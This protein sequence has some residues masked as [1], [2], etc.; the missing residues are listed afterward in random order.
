M[1]PD[2]LN[3]LFV[4]ISALDGVGPENCQTV[5]APAGRGD[6]TEPRIVR[7]I[8][9]LPHAVID[10][11]KQPGIA[12]SPEGAIV[13]LKVRVDRHQPSPPGKPNHPYKVFVHDDTGEL[14]LT[15]FHMKQP[16][17]E[18]SL[19]IGETVFV[20]GKME[21]FNGRPTMV[22][23]D[24]ITPESGLDALPLIEPVYAMTEGL[25]PKTI[26]K[27]VTQALAR[28]PE[29]PE[30]HDPAL[31]A[32]QSFKPF[33]AALD[34]V[35]HPADPMDIDPQSSSRRRL[36][37]DELLA[38]Q[39]S[40]ALVRSRM[41]KMP[42]KALT[43]NGN[44]RVKLLHSI[45]YSL[46]GSQKTALAEISADLSKPDRMLRLL[47]GDVGSGK[48]IVALLAM[49][50]AAEAGGQSALMA[51]TEVLARQHLCDNWAA[52]GTSGASH[53]DLDQQ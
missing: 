39:L 26:R 30:W 10:R 33:K 24:Y 29:F 4:G 32:K 7:L 9:H 8:T 1:R 53:C 44:I 43:G 17:L 14:G 49:A 11:R 28:L 6:G 40:L 38:G 13:T 41:R 25:S 22:H 36:A 51:P 42:G 21:W 37:Y 20:S 23:P 2:I 46:T 34:A 47:Q 19:P 12:F 52:G 48:T 35:H 31:L 15:F 16:W 5:R 18:K 50:Q 3:P 27:A 45:P